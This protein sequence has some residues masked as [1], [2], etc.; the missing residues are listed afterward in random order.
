MDS[1]GVAKPGVKR[2]RDE[3]RQ[4]TST[5]VAE[6]RLRFALEPTQAQ[7]CMCHEES[8]RMQV[9]ELVDGAGKVKYL[10]RPQSIPEAL[11][12]AWR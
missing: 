9:R 5:S 10:D 11:R 1:G 6:K 12:S 3:E 2:R 8:K 7:A 4:A